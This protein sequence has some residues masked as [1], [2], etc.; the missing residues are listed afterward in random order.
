MDYTPTPKWRINLAV[1]QTTTK[2]PTSASPTFPGDEFIDRAGGTKSNRVS[3]SLGIDWTAT[4]TLINA[5][6]FGYLYPPSWNPWGESEAFEGWRNYPQ[7]VG[8][9]I[10]TSPMTWNFPIS[11]YY[12]VFTIADTVNWQKGSARAQLRILG[13]SGDMIVI[14][15]GPNLPLSVSVW[16]LAI[17]LYDALTNAGSYQPLPFATTTQQAQVRATCMPC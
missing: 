13:V 15:I 5:F 2:A 6:R 8:W 9:N 10:V 16:S 17:P 14:G 1:N 7:T 11:N 3:S 12:P 4:N